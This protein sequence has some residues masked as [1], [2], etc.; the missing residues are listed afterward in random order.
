M[1]LTILVVEPQQREQQI[2]SHPANGKPQ[3]RA[4]EVEHRRGGS[5]QKVTL[6][7]KFLILIP[8]LDLP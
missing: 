4:N 5:Q 8:F 2:V 3:E 7:H 1:A 6:C